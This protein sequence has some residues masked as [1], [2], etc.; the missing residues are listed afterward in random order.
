MGVVYVSRSSAVCGTIVSV[1]AEC[2]SCWV[3]CVCEAVLCVCVAV[4]CVCSCSMCV[5]VAVLCVC[6]CRTGE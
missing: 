5:C 4:L 3:V 1:I 6:V 2:Y